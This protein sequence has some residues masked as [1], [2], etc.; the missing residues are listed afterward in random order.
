M[1]YAQPS[2]L[3]K[4]SRMVFAVPSMEISSGSA[5]RVSLQW[6]AS[7]EDWLSHQLL[8]RQ[9]PDDSLEAMSLIEMRYQQHLAQR[10]LQ[11]LFENGLLQVLGS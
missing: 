10:D 3:G 6:E 5:A 1:T 2:D 7:T 8:S 11:E 9:P 4:E